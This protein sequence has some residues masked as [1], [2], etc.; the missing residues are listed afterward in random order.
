MLIFAM[1][2]FYNQSKAM[3]IA[4]SVWLF[5]CPFHILKYGGFAPCM[6]CNGVCKPSLRTLT[7]GSGTVLFLMSK[8]SKL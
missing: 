2:K 3:D 4:G 6:H 8:I 1:S 5:L 7:T